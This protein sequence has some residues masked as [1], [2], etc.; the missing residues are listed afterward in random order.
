MRYTCK[1]N[2]NELRTSY[3]YLVGWGAGRDEYDRRYNL[4]LY[5]LD[6]MIDAAEENWGKIRCGIMMESQEILKNLVG[7]KVCFIIYPNIELEIMPEIEKYLKE[8][9][10][11]AS[12]LIDCPQA[13]YLH[14]YATANEDI[15]FTQLI[16]A[17]GIKNPLYVDIG[18][19][20]PVV[21]N[22]TYLLYEKGYTN[23]ILIE[24][25]GN[26][27]ELAQIYRPKNKIVEAGASGDE[28]GILRYYMNHQSSLKGYNTFNQEVAEREGFADNYKDV[29]VMNIN[30]ILEENCTKAPDIIDIDTESMDFEILEAL[31]T[32]RFRVKLICVEV[33][34]REAEFSQMMEKKGYVH[35]MSTIENTLYIAKEAAEQL[36]NRRIR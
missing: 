30:R 16:E 28:G 25:N 15:I 27:C 2:I 24:P 18:V 31:D 21:R 6:Y 7:K 14:S 33:W 17:L 8:Y 1:T 13:P 9:D 3:D 5:Q 19:C 4:S 10:F 36:R 26:M 11:I 12:R 34:G 32:D 23:G 22:N 35:Y 29:P 20:H